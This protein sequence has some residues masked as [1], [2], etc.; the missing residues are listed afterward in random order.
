MTQEEKHNLDAFE[1]FKKTDEFKKSKM[2]CIL[3]IDE[4]GGTRVFQSA[5][6]S[7]SQL[8]EALIAVGRKIANLITS[9]H[10]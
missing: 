10:N 8:A 7:P 5:V 2:F 4:K 6:F 3:S 9:K 1:N